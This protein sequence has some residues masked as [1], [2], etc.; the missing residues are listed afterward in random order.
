MRT[1]G[2]RV[3]KKLKFIL[4]LL[5][6]VIIVSAAV[7]LFQKNDKISNDQFN[8]LVK[9][10]NT[11]FVYQSKEDKQSE[12]IEVREEFKVYDD[13][14]KMANTKVVADAIWGTLD[15]DEER[16]N[17]LIIEVLKSDFDDK[18]ELEAILTNWKKGDFT[19]CVDEH[20]YF[21]SKLNGSVGEAT[22]LK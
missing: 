12:D 21:W 18:K 3:S 14:H 16:I 6:I 11:G 20:N 19:H 9:T 2:S 1:K 17:K 8:K 15:M 4:M 22:G 10:T 13:M 7:V 5:G